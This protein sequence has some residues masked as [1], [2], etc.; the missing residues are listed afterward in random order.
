MVNWNVINRNDNT[1]IIG[2]H[3]SDTQ[4]TS[5]V[6]YHHPFPF[7]QNFSPFQAFTHGNLIYF[8]APKK[9][10]HTRIISIINYSIL[11]KPKLYSPEAIDTSHIITQPKRGIIFQW[12]NISRSDCVRTTPTELW[13]CLEKYTTQ[14]TATLCLS[15]SSLCC[16]IIARNTVLPK[17]GWLSAADA[18]CSSDYI[19]SGHPSRIFAIFFLLFF[20]EDYWAAAAERMRAKCVCVSVYVYVC[21]S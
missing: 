17:A 18:R 16:Y 19:K 13:G 6:R 1:K 7:T 3:R 12:W 8:S 9:R 14:S 20:F 11:P 21:V 5:F 4:T 2:T 15:V 10:K